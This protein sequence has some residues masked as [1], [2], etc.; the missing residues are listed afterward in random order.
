MSREKERYKTSDPW[1]HGCGYIVMMTVSGEHAGKIEGRVKPGTGEIEI[2]IK[3]PDTEEGRNGLDRMVEIIKKIPSRKTK[4]KVL[5]TIHVATGYG[6][7]LAESGVVE[8]ESIEY[9][10]A[11]A[12]GIAESRIAQIKGEKG[13]KGYSHD[14]D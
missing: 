3:T 11:A 2:R 5:E 10:V 14:E 8:K 1:M 13:G 9:L 6:L 4:R 12:G 7:C